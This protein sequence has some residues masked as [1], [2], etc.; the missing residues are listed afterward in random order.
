MPSGGKIDVTHAPGRGREL[1]S[2]RV[3]CSESLA[4]WIFLGKVRT[5][6]MPYIDR[7]DGCARTRVLPNRK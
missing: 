7:M 1:D 4:A 3:E 5:S 6:Y 2:M